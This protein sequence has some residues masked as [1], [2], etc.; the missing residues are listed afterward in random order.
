MVL[1]AAFAT[2]LYRRSG[3]DDILFG[4]PMA[5]RDRP[6]LEH[7]IGFFANTI[8]VRAKLRGN[9]RFADLL[10]TVRESVLASYE[11]QEVPLDSFVVDAVRPQRDPGVNPLF[12]VNFRVRVGPAPALELERTTT[13]QGP[14]RPGPRPLR[15]SARAARARQPAPGRVQLE[16]GLL[17]RPR[18]RASPPT[19]SAYCAPPW[20]SRFNRE[21]YRYS[22]VNTVAQ[23]AGRYQI[24]VLQSTDAAAAAALKA[25]NPQLKVLMYQA[26]IHSVTSDPT[27]LITCTPYG[28]DNA[29]NRSFFLADQVRQPS[30]RPDLRRV[31][32]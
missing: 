11:H 5:N 19:S 2:L 31:P 21:T 7:L 14:R 28:T 9:P 29:S 18:S 13:T 30:R 4:G 25:A 24:M 23:E 17:R 1:L 10:A 16:H 32:I 6:G 22:S 27:G 3:Q 26:A 12:Q 8:V 20:Q 15:P